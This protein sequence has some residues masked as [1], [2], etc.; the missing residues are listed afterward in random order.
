[1]AADA[2]I[3]REIAGYRI[4]ALIG[5]GGM[6]VV[7]RAE[8]MLLGRRDALKVLAGELAED[9]G[10][11]E[12]FL[13]ES[14]LAA[15]IEH[16]NIIQ[17]YHAGAADGLLYI[18]MR[19]I[20]G[21]D[22][23]ELL[24]REGPME[25]MRAVAMIEQVARALD[26]AH[27]SGLV[28]RDVKPANILIAREDRVYLS[29]FGIAKQAATSGLTKTGSFVGTLDYAAP[30]QIEGK[31]LDGRADVYSL[32]CVLCEC[33]T[34]IVPYKKDSEVQVLYAHL[35]EPPPALTARRPELGAG[36]DTVIAKALA[37]SPDDRYATCCELV[38]ALRIALAGGAV[39]A[40]PGTLA[41][42]PTKAAPRIAE[43]APPPRIEAPAATPRL[44]RRLLR[45]LRLHLGSPPSRRRNG[46]RHT[47]NPAGAAGSGSLLWRECWRRACSQSSS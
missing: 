41:A 12:R 39:A 32:G 8:H 20:E 47:R 35:L 29:D 3:G 46:P 26:M 25:P 22:L 17:I 14:R 19:Y 9:A 13:R 10:F 45:R 28:H 15:A 7:Y 36:V 1:M 40:A 27:A 37:K 44:L 23:R 21:T 38:D 5:R 31:A 4:E 43:T 42:P 6:G 30:E 18:A 2:L 24:K 11:R 16:P 33:L 34:G